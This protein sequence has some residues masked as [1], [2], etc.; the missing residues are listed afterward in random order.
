MIYSHWV[1]ESIKGLSTL[2]QVLAKAL[3]QEKSSCW[4]LFST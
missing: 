3:G 1:V 4:E 2:K